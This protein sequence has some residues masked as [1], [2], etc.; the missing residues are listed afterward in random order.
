[1][2]LWQMAL[3]LAHMDDDAFERAM[4]T[5]HA[6]GIGYDERCR[7]GG[8]EWYLWDAL[9]HE[10]R[11]PDEQGPWQNADYRAA[12]AAR[13]ADEATLR[14][15]LA[16]TKQRLQDAPVPAVRIGYAEGHRPPSYDAPGMVLGRWFP[17]PGG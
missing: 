7:E 8:R 5:D 6:V 10:L 16:L 4:A 11:L 17:E 9:A 1:M 13:F 3:A 15:A 12:I 2:C 14:T